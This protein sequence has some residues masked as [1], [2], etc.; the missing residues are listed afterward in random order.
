MQPM[1]GSERRV[2]V[3]VPRLAMVSRRR[4]TR[5]YFRCLREVELSDFVPSKVSHS[6]QNSGRLLRSPLSCCRC[7][8]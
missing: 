4:Q 2:T 7:C 6:G 8:A 5:A 3:R 1:R